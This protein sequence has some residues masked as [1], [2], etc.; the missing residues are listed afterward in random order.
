MAMMEISVV[1]LGTGSPSV[2][3]Y[4]AGAVKILKEEPGI[5]YELTAMG[6]VVVGDVD[7]L[8]SLAARMHRSAL[9]AGALR[10]VTT[11][12]IDERTDKPLTIDGKKRAVNEK[13]G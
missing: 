6:T 12:K 5:T 10:A 2:S 1:P 13:L 11:I 7:T 8:L 3:R 4:V 9:E